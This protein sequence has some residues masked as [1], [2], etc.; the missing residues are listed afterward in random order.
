M[1]ITSS[2]TLPVGNEKLPMR[3]G[4]A[5]EVHQLTGDGS[6]TSIAITTVTVPKVEAVS[7]AG[8]TYT[9]SGQ[10]V[11]LTFGTAPGNGLKLDAI[12]T[13]REW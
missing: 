8:A 1:A 7:C 2:R 13:G 9:V 11:T 12:I 6:A 5:Q 4:R 3:G 10:T